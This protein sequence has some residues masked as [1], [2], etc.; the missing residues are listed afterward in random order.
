MTE[1]EIMQML[2]D[3]GSDKSFLTSNKSP[4]SILL[5]DFVND[6]VSQLTKS[7][8]KYGISAS[9]NLK[10]SIAPTSVNVN[11]NIVEVGVSAPFYWKYVNYGVNGFV[12]KHGAPNWGS[13]GTTRQQF[14]ES[15]S[16]WRMNV[17][18]N[19][20]HWKGKNGKPIYKNYSDLDDA[21]TYLIARNGKEA[22][23]FFTDVVNDTLINKLENDLSLLLEK[24]IEVKI[25]EPWQ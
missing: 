1:S 5:Q 15:I 18:M 4:L 16:A 17:G 13:T 3:V 20:N 6:V 24:V 25:I 10:Q 9:N 19:L 2:S 12:K 14:K 23:P 8:E 7:V 21:L 22:R 11:N